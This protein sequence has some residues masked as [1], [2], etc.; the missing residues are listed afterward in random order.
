LISPLVVIV[1]IAR[2]HT[3]AGR[4]KTHVQ[5]FREQISAQKELFI[6]PLI[7]IIS[8]LPEFIISFNFACKELNIPWQRRILT[9]AYFLSYLPQ[10]LT[11]FIHIQPST[12][13][14][15][16]FYLT[17]IGKIIQLHAQKTK[18]EPRT[19]ITGVKDH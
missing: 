1:L 2:H 14:K 12:L 5:V 4:K 7:I 3:I 10:T 16:E 19:A 15:C 9:V 11:F 8:A 18:Q 13:F 6:P 17:R